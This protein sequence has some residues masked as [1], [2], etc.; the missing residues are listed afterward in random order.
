MVRIALIVILVLFVAIQLVR[1]ETNE[2]GDNSGH[3]KTVLPMSD[4]VEAILSR[5][6]YD[7]HSN[8]TT[9]PWYFR[10]QPVAWWMN[11]HIEEGKHDLNFSAFAGY[12]A[13]RQYR[14]L[15]GLD[16]AIQREFM[17]LDSYLWI[18]RDAKLD[19]AQKQAIH[20]WVQVACDSLMRKYP[21]DSLK[22]PARPRRD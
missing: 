15:R 10:I 21:A 12:P 9:Y 19:A 5:S 4:N 6:C 3:L 16:T 18:H 1:P 7:C 8:H 14:K 11:D 2:T 20:E 13:W 17:P 22:A